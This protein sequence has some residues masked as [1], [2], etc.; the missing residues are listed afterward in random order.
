[1]YT[2]QPWN[3]GSLMSTVDRSLVVYIVVN[4]GRRVRELCGGPA[5]RTSLILVLG[6]SRSLG[7]GL[8]SVTK[9]VFGGGLHFR[10]CLVDVVT[11]RG[12]L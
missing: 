12:C 7:G 4:T 10:E 8:V 3:V 11:G 1:M 2:D 6:N 9:D 5:G